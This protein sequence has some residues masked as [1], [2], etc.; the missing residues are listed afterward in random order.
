[1]EN[2][3]FS[4]LYKIKILFKSLLKLKKNVIV[5]DILLISKIFL[6]LPFV[7]SHWQL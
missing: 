7:F 5:M 3:F 1:M 2:P 4:N 6:L